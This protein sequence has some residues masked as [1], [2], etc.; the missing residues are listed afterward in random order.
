[1]QNWLILRTPC[2]GK[3]FSRAKKYLS[4][5][6]TV[7]WQYNE[8]IGSNSVIS[9]PGVSLNLGLN[10][11]WRHT[12]FNSQLCFQSR[13]TDGTFSSN[14]RSLN[15][16][17]NSWSPQG[18]FTSN[19]FN[20]NPRTSQSCFSCCFFCSN[21]GL[22]PGSPQSFLLFDSFSCYVR[23]NSWPSYHFLFLDS[24]SFKLSFKSCFSVSCYLFCSSCFNFCLNFVPSICLVSS[25]FFSC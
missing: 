3:E 9:P 23:F 5:F 6:D 25:C 15:F 18:I 16:S 7:K 10:T 19:N 2:K 4:N 8:A 11:R 24:F 13:T 1:M 17:L 12:V 20:L 21:L 22:N 14:T